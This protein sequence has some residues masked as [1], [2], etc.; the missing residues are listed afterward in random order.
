MAAHATNVEK[1]D[2]TEDLAKKI[3]GM[4]EEEQDSLLEK[5]L[6]F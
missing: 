1:K 6:D 4:A 2:T 5:L 3:Q